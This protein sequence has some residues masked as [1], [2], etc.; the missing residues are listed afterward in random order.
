MTLPFKNISKTIQTDILVI[1]ILLY[2]FRSTIPFLKFPFL[3][4]LFCIIIYSVTYFRLQIFST[5]REFFLTFKLA[6][7]LAIF[8]IISFLFSNKLYLMIFKDI[9]NTV[10]LFSLFFLLS[11]FIKSKDDLELF[12]VRLVQIIVVF[13][14]LISI[15][16]LFNFLGGDSITTNDSV[17]RSVSSDNNFALLSVFFGMT[18]IIFSLTG[19]ITTFKK[20]VLNLMLLF[21]SV[22]I[23]FSGSR[24]GLFMLIAI[25]IIV[26]AIQLFKHNKKYYTGSTIG[27]NTTLFRISILVLSIIMSGCVFFVPISMKRT[28]LKTLGIDIRTYKSVVTSILY[29]YTSIFKDQEYKRLEYLIWPEK[30]DSR[31]PETGWGSRH[32]TLI[33]DLSGEN[34]D[35]VPKGSVG[36]KMDMTSNATVWSN[37]AYSYTN[38]SSLYHD[39][40]LKSNEFFYASV[41]CFVSKDFDGSWAHIST[42]G[43]V[44][45]KTIQEYD[46]NRK[47]VWQKLSITFRNAGNI[48]PVYLYWAKNGVTDFSNLKGSIIFTYPEYTKIKANSLDPATGWGTRKSYSVF[49]LTGDNNEIVPK[50]SIGYKMDC[51]S[52]ASTWNNNAYSFT[53]ITALFKSDSTTTTGNSY[54]ALVYCYVSKD[55]DGSWARISV[56]GAA[57]G[58]TITEYDLRRKGTWQMLKIDFE[59]VTGIPPVYLYWSKNKV[60][61]FSSLKGYIIFAHPEYGTPATITGFNN[62]FLPSVI[63]SEKSDDLNK[64]VGTIMKFKDSEISGIKLLSESEMDINL[65]ESYFFSF[66]QVLNDTD[67]DPVRRWA[68]KIISEDTTYFAPKNLLS[69]DTI[70]NKMT[71]PRLMRWEFAWQIYKEEFNTKQ[72][73]FGGGFNFLNWFG[74]KFVKDKTISDYPHNPFLSILL[75]SGILGLILYLTLF[76]KVIYYNVLYF[77]KYPVISIFFGITFFFSFFSAGSPFDPPVMGFFI[78]LPF[79]IQNILFPKSIS[80]G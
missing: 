73:L 70:I 14:F 33:F 78:L 80:N 5:F 57:T 49:P 65:Y 9:S 10:I 27:S 7:I 4:L 44:S 19:K 55:F 25:I 45:G 50:G 32:S 74:Y 30:P 42:E 8:L 72:K 61:D 35:I 15:R 1:T 69:I 22:T 64:R 34:A 47:G 43:K 66:F 79:F 60:T 36:Y 40:S 21:F 37:N 20:T 46:M 17:L 77:K 75:Y 56:E 76:Y 58:K 29:K 63:S 38:I 54:S 26:S 68:A 23:L 13:A 48:S 16:L 31:Y 62:T 28:T 51:T 11:I 12:I 2:L 59:S 71:G 6:L 41:Y 53:S 3:I 52:N 24:R 39:G 67:T 18:S